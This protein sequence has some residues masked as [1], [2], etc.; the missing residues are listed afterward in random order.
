MV[1][2]TGANGF[3]GSMILKDL[4]ENSAD[5]SV[6][7][8]DL[9]L[10]SLVGVDS[11]P[12]SERNLIPTNSNI[13]F[14][15][16]DELWDFLKT[17]EAHKL[18]WIIH[19]GACSSTTET[20]WQFLEENNVYYSQRLFEWCAEHKRNL[21]YASSAAT[22]GDGAVGFDDRKSISMLQPLNLYGHSKHIFD[23]WVLT[24][25]K[26]PPH[27]YGLKFFNVYGP[28]EDHKKDMSSIAYKAFHQIKATGELGLFKSYHPDYKDGEQKRDF[29]YVKDICFWM[30]ELMV[31]K[32][33]NDIYNMGSGKARTWLDLGNAVFSALEIK[34]KIKWLEMPENLKTQ[35]QYFTEA[36]MEKWKQQGLSSP[37]WSLEDGVKDYVTTYLKKVYG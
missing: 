14:L 26:T 21:I 8:H 13:K 3:I 24:Q 16:K 28:Q 37:R 7:S 34:P 20:N 31:R 29:V 17:P 10:K 12:L 27:W 5:Y 1:L 4:F 33:K 2:V 6:A 25:R 11:V 19:M 32:P 22:Y 30:R 15:A 35:Y 9:D 18:T 23:E 36:S